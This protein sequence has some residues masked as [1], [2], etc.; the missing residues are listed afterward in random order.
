MRQVIKCMLFG[1]V[2][3]LRRYPSLSIS[4]FLICSLVLTRYLV[5]RAQVMNCCGSKAHRSPSPSPAQPATMTEKP[6]TA[7]PT[8]GLPAN[9]LSLN[10]MHIGFHP[11][12][13]HE[14]NA[15]SI[16]AALAPTGKSMSI[17]GDFVQITKS[18]MILNQVCLSSGELLILKS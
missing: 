6:A 8:L 7:D 4:G 11:P 1:L 3:L 9:G 16:N 2:S 13:G 14:D 18:D 10:G 17:I 15:A 12:Y 5:I